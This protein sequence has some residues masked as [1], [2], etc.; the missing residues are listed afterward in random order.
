MGC[1]VSSRPGFFSERSYHEQRV[2]GLDAV[3]FDFDFVGGVDAV[4]R[5]SSR[6]F[7]GTSSLVVK[8]ESQNSC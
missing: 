8:K 6:T 7:G 2:L 3:L 4:A 5:Q 1:E